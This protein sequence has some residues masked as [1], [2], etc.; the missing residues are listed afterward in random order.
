MRR[1]HVHVAVDDIPKSTT[2]YTKLFGKPARVE[3]DYVKWML[4]DPRLNFAISSRGQTSG[5][6]H[7][8]L[9]MDSEE[10]LKE[11]L[12]QLESANLIGDSET[13]SHCCYS[14]SDKYWVTDPQGI[15]WETYHTLSSIPTFGG[16][17]SP[18]CGSATQ[19]AACCAPLAIEIA[20][21]PKRTSGCCS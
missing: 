2:F 15:A 5:V 19:S 20:E 9:Q 21:M 13:A 10:E 14:S 1:F 7:L 3:A 8:G 16:E 12:A 6:N 4:E 17:S 11:L 18:A